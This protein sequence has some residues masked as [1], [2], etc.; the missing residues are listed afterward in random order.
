MLEHGNGLSLQTGA[1]K[2]IAS[3]FLL[4]QCDMTCRFCAS[5]EDF[6]VMSFD[7]A[8]NLLRALRERSIRNVVLGGGE[9]FLWPHGLERLSRVARELGFLVQICTNGVSL[10]AGFERIATVDRYI[11]PVESMDAALHDGLRR[12][13]RGHHN[14]VLDRIAALAGSGRELTVST[15]VTAENVDRLGEIADFLARERERGVALHAWHLYRFLPVGRGG[16]VH[17][18]RL[19]VARED[20]RRACA[21]VRRRDLGFRVY[22]RDDMRRSSTVE[23]FWFERGRLRTGSESLTRAVKPAGAG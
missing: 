2:R 11:L 9:P 16:A 4:P 5:E 14:V 21:A 8:A 1:R 17:A 12:H 10:P 18:G 6:S 15:V 23:F 20:Y 19:D 13:R 7:Q 3:L 22:R